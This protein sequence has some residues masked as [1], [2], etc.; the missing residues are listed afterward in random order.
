[1]LLWQPPHGTL[2]VGRDVRTYIFFTIMA[3]LK[4]KISA[5]LETGSAPQSQ[6]Y[7]AFTPAYH[8]DSIYKAVNVLKN[9]QQVIDHAAELQLSVT[10]RAALRERIPY[11]RFRDHEWDGLW[12]LVFFDIPEQERSHRDRFRK[13]LK[14]HGFGLWPEFG[15]GFS[16]CA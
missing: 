7:A 1:M 6:L 13:H 5:Y 14:A 11:F 16:V 10:G 8:R 2:D 4:D 12:R 15:L 9:E 3:A